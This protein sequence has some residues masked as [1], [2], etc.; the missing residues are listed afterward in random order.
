MKLSVILLTWNSEKYAAPCLDSLLNAIRHI[1]HEIF[2]IDNGSTD[3]TLSILE[4]YQSDKIV[5]IKNTQNRG[6]AAARNQGLKLAKG[7]YVWILDI[8][9]VVNR[10]AIDCLLQEMNN[11]SK[12]GVA[13]CKLVAESGDVQMSCRKF[14][15]VRYKLFNIMETLGIH[16]KNNNGQFYTDE[17]NG[18]AAFEADYVIGACQLIRKEALD[19]A[20]PLDE[21]IFYGP[22]D[23]DFCRRLKL[24]Q[25]KTVC[26]PTVS[27]IHHYQQIS[28]KSLLS[29]I[30]LSHLKGLIYFFWKWK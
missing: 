4:K 12:I 11:D 13:G 18:N 5:I 6:V 28:H 15:T 1:D 19:E 2:V 26:I 7:D 16:I 27:I 10:E 14:P 3:N 21:H 24:L 20:G 9:T 30:S 25:W 17:L 8:D 22:E 23:A 29:K